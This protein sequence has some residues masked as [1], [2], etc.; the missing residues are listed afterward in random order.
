MVDSRSASGLRV[1][2]PCGPRKSGMPESVEIPAP[3]SAVT[4]GD[5]ITAGYGLAVFRGPYADGPPAA[6]LEVHAPALDKFGLD[7][8][9]RMA[10]T[11]IVLTAAVLRA[12]GGWIVRRRG[13]SFAQ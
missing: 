8:L 10:L 13:R 3:V 7:E 5:A 6:A 12:I 11:T 2:I 9:R 1:Q 4:I